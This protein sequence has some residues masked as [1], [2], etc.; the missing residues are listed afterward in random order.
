MVSSATSLVTTAPAPTMQRSPMVMP[1]WMMAPPPIQQS[2]PMR[3][4]LP[5]SGPAAR[6]T[7]SSGWVAVNTCT[8]GPNIVRA[9]MWTGH[10]SS[11]TQLKFM[12]TFSSA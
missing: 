8:A 2:R 6:S 5:Y 7:A 3:M 12:N 4:G 11:T 9:P 10:T 1:G